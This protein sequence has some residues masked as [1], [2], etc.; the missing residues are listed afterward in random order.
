MY[1][2]IKKI[3]ENIFLPFLIEPYLFSILIASRICSCNDVCQADHKVIPIEMTFQIKIYS[4][5]LSFGG[6][7]TANQFL[8]KKNI[9]TRK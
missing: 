3:L 9:S 6:C 5:L 4:F 7:C 2:E 1:N 8:K